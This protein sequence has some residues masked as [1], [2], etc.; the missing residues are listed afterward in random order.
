MQKSTC[1]C[2]HEHTCRTECNAV[3]K[4]NENLKNKTVKIQVEKVN[5]PLY[6]T[7]AQKKVLSIL[8]ASKI[9]C[10]NFKLSTYCF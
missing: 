10:A 5:M 9:C 3:S 4:L 7:S 2:W 6:L 8:I 1:L